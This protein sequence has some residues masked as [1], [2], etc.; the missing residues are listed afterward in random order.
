MWEKNP[1]VTALPIITSRADYQ[2]SVVVK[3][4]FIISGDRMLVSK[5]EPVNGLAC[6]ILVSFY[7]YLVAS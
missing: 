7:V 3:L 5:K 6:H 1:L 2:T 4:T